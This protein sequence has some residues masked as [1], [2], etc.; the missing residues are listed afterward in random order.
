MQKQNKTEQKKN[1]TLQIINESF[2]DIQKIQTQDV[3][4]VFPGSMGPSVVDYIWLWA[5]GDLV[6]CGR[7]QTAD[8]TCGLTVSA[9]APPL[10]PSLLKCPSRSRCLLSFG[11]RRKWPPVT[12]RSPKSRPPH[13][14]SSWRWPTLKAKKKKWKR[15]IKKKKKRKTTGL[16]LSKWVQ[17]WVPLTNLTLKILKFSTELNIDSYSKKTFEQLNK[18][19]SKLNHSLFADVINIICLHFPPT[20]WN[21]EWYS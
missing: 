7:P 19:G 9:S 6:H 1:K 2:A 10:T 16:R 14:S 12:P 4:S 17:C 15:E 18:T 3:V 13:F 20:Q 8:G 5:W 11:C 21:R